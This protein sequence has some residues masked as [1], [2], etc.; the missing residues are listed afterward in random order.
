MSS[1]TT[2]PA[3]HAGSSSRLSGRLG[4]M[5]IVFMVVAAAAPLTIF[6]STPINML[7]GNQAGTAFSYIVGPL[8]MLVFGAGFAAM[9]IHVQKAGAFY[10]Y[11]T[12]A[13]GRPVGVGS[14]FLAMLG[15]AMFQ[16]FVY[17][18]LGFSMEG[19]LVS[20]IGTG[21]LPWWG[22]TI[23]AMVGVALLGYMNIDMSAKVLAVALVL[24]VIVVLVI[25]FAILI[26]GGGPEG[27]QIAPFFSPETIAMGSLPL[28]ILFGISV[29]LGFEATAIFRDEARDPAKTIPRAIYISII[30]AALFY[31]F[32]IWAWMQA[33]GVNGVMDAVAGDPVN[34]MYTTAAEWVGPI[35]MQVMSVL[36]VTSMFA[37]VLSYHN[38][39]TRYLH[40]LGHSVLPQRLTWVHKRHNSPYVASVVA[41]VIAL[42][43]LVLVLV[44][45]VD[46]FVVFGWQIAVGTL[47]PLVLFTLTSVAI[48]VFFRKN[49][50]LPVSR[51]SS[52][53]APILSFFLLGSIALIALLNFSVLSAADPAINVALQLTPVVVFA[54]GIVVA[55]I[56]RKVSPER[57]A[58]L[59]DHGTASVR[60]VDEPT[61][62]ESSTD[63]SPEPIGKA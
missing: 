36:A 6:I 13:M 38:I 1:T 34:I 47:S 29:G 26:Q 19:L 2:E 57:Y 31:G 61:A 55:V 44:S 43:L 24:E 33:F 12:A 28:G 14:G 8:I 4:P 20:F 10:S 50:N 21:L 58:G 53:I 7:N 42:V 51:W 22:W 30:A 35:F 27:I 40:S 17:M 60:V 11:I 49:R 18:L 23:V 39:M 56:A 59:K 63:P 45:G 62:A 32:A 41:S 46:P 52:T 25:D 37:C 48:F 15:Y 16:S 54:I 5:S 9:S 3:Q